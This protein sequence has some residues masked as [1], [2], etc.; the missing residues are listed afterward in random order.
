MSEE[1]K[2]HAKSLAKKL[3]DEGIEIIYCSPK[4]RA[5][6]TATILQKGLNCKAETI[7][8]LR[9][10]NQYGILTGMLKS[11]AKQKYPQLVELLKNKARP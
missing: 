9:E 3:T 6:E 4:I 7:D 8:D 2:L 10:G 11:K 1:G 5:Q